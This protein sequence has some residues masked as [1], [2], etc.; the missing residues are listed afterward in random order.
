MDVVSLACSCDL[1]EVTSQQARIQYLFV[2]VFAASREGMNES[3]EFKSQSGRE[4][5]VIMCVFVSMTIRMFV[6]FCLYIRQGPIGVSIYDTC[7]SYVI[8][9]YTYIIHIRRHCS[10]CGHMR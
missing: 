3:M 5:K 6:M 7:M 9:V 4:E 1:D 8:Y 2:L 10:L